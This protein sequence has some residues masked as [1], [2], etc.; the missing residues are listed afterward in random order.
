M[1][2]TIVPDFFFKIHS[3]QKRTFNYVL[4]T[5]TWMNIPQVLRWLALLIVWV[6]YWL[7]YLSIGGGTWQIL[8]KGNNVSSSRII[9]RCLRR[10]DCWQLGQLCQ[11]KSKTKKSMHNGIVYKNSSVREKMWSSGHKFCEKE[12]G[13]KLLSQ[14]FV[15]EIFHSYSSAYPSSVF[16]KISQFY[17]AD[18]NLYYF[19]LNL[20]IQ[21]I[22][23]C[24]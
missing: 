16:I 8:I 24:K 23:Y 4:C 11:R 15:G 5:C 17:K 10:C 13:Q 21:K 2:E 20:R 14:N 7:W 6:G 19:Q 1:F 3:W 18:F 9:S 12:R 22:L